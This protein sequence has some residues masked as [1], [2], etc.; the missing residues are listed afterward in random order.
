VCAFARVGGD[1]VAVTVIPRLLARRGIDAL[2]LG[3]EYWADTWLPLP[4]ELAGVYSNAFT[5]ERVETGPAG[6][7]L[8]L[9]LGD[10]LTAFPTALLVRAPA[11]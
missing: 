9:R 2:P 10:V 5:A 3:P 11:A 7:G 8:S 4:R 6:D 1:A